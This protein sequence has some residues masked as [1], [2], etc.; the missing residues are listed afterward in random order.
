[1]GE[2]KR[3]MDPESTEGFMG[4]AAW[5]DPQAALCGTALGGWYQTCGRV[6]GTSTTVPGHECYFKHLNVGER[7]KE[8]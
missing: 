1:M 3:F 8:I 7:Q 4:A 2:I 5:K 6:A